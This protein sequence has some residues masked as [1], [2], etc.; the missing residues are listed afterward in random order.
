MESKDKDYR[1]IFVTKLYL[2]SI[3]KDKD[4][5]IPVKRHQKLFKNF[6]H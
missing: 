4:P 3:A 6:C 1:K 2:V 5:S